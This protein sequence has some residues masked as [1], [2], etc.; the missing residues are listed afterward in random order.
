[1]TRRLLRI[2]IAALLASAL[3]TLSAAAPG[4]PAPKAAG[5]GAY[6]VSFVGTLADLG[7]R[8]PRQTTQPVKIWIDRLTSDSEAEHLSEVVRAKGQNALE[9]ALFEDS[10][11]RLQIGDRLGYP[12]AFARRFVDADGEHLLLIAQRPISFRE[13]FRNT[14]SRDYPFTVVE[15]DLDVS[16]HGSG[17]V[18]S[19]ARIRT[20]RNGEIE[21][22][23]LDV[24]AG[25]L[26]AVAPVGG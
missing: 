15:L 19:A 17:E 22:L 12:I 2:S 9:Q 4:A 21:L 16:G 14:R 20:R 18:L 7:D 5:D 1:M 25:R 24:R 26:L 23:N 6:R 8:L 11:G 3:P 13:I 10:V